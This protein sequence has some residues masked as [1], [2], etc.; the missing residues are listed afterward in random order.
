MPKDSKQ[1]NSRGRIGFSINNFANNEGDESKQS[2]TSEPGKKFE[3]GTVDCVETRKK[4]NWQR[5]GWGEQP[6]VLSMKRLLVCFENILWIQQRA[7]T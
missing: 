4:P 2:N 7:G 6:I 3:K 1:E 5:A